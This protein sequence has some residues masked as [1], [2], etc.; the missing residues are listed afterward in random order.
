M[1]GYTL[2]ADLSYHAQFVLKKKEIVLGKRFNNYYKKEIKNLQY[3]C[4]LTS[5]RYRPRKRHTNRALLCLNRALIRLNRSLI[6][7]AAVSCQKWPKY[8]SVEHCDNRESQSTVETMVSP[9]LRRALWITTFLH[10]DVI[11]WTDL[12]ETPFDRTVRARRQANLLKH[13]DGG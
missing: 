1:L 6:C 2:V 11:V 7:T 13:Y 10:P 9:I 4:L 5:E 8:G 3:R 12:R